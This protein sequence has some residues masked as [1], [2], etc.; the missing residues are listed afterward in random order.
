MT[1]SRFRC[2]LEAKTK[3][4]VMKKILVATD[5]SAA[6]VEAVSFAIELA[7]EQHATVAFV[8]VVPVV[9]ALPIGGF[10]MTGAMLHTVCEEDRRP[11]EDAAAIAAEHGVDWTTELLTGDTVHEIVACADSFDADLIVV[12][13]RGHGALTSALLGSV[14]RG[15]LRESKRPVLIV[16]GLATAKVPA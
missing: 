13:S 2:I 12:G 16:R 4:V 8:H 1:V 5:G 6:A 7:V 10:G 14:S 3:E 11:L 9:D 15:V